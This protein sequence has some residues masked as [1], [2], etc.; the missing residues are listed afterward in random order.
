MQSASLARKAFQAHIRAY[1]TH[2]AAEKHLFNLKAV[3][4]GHL[5]KSFGMREAPG[6][7]LAS[8]NGGPARKK[9]RMGNSNGVATGGSFDDG[10]GAG[11]F[12]VG[13]RR[14]TLD[15]EARM[16]KLMRGPQANGGGEFQIA[17]VGELEGLVSR[18]GSSSKR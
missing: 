14:K 1:A 2:P 4:L 6:H 16:R 13:R 11:G 3:H 12:E 15:A 7:H 17:G 10:S 18:G 9:A 8:S 5:A